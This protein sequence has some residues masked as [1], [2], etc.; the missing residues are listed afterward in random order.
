MSDLEPFP[1]P[2]TLSKRQLAV[3][4]SLIVALPLALV[5]W[6][7]F[8]LD[9]KPEPVLDAQISTGVMSFSPDDTPQRTRLVPALVI[10]NNSQDDW[11][12]VSASLNDQFFYYHR[13]KLRA[14]RE[15]KI[16][17]EFFATKGNSVFQAS[18][19]KLT[20]V[21]LFAQIPSGARGVKEEEMN[22]LR[23]ESK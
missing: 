23:I 6:M 7:A 14:G 3:A 5:A 4:A 22:G 20:K 19:N 18:S 15:L 17:L 21:T 1:K 16:P 9:V 2:K 11:G 13:E 10:T 12:N 8:G